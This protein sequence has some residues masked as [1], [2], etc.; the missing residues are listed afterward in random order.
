MGDDW[1]HNEL[2]ILYLNQITM[3]QFMFIARVYYLIEAFKN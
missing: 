2:S 3:V 1:E